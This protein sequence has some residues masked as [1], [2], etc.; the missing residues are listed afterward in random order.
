MLTALPTLDAVLDAH[1]SALGDDAL[2]YRHHAYRVANFSWLL[3]PGDAE[4]LEK[5]SIAVAFH[6]LGIWTAGTFDYLPPSRAL[7]RDHLHQ[8]GKAAWMVEVDA[9]IECHHKL[10]RTAAGTSPAVEAFRRADW[11]D[12][13][14]GVRRFGLSRRAVR[15]V[16]TAF[17]DAGFHRRL[18]ELTLARLRCHPLDPLPM[19][20]W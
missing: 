14:L 17:P 2:G 7:A 9:M 11:I 3:A 6:D 18:A 16:M 8:A 20:R 4:A 19:M 10:V 12:V 5:L 1:A 15:E 13:S